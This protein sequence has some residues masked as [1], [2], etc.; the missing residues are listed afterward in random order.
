MD[1][2]KTTLRVQQTVA[3][4]A[5]S[6]HRQLVPLNSTIQAPTGQ[7]IP[8][9][10]TGETQLAPH[11][12]RQRSMLDRP[13]PQEMTRGLE[14][15]WISAR[16]REL[17]S[18]ENPNPQRFKTAF[19]DTPPSSPFE[20]W[21]PDGDAAE[22]V[23]IAQTDDT[24]EHHTATTTTT[25]T[26]TTALQDPDDFLDSILHAD[27][28]I[29]VEPDPVFRT[30][31]DQASTIEHP[32]PIQNPGTPAKPGNAFVEAIRKGMSS[33]QQAFAGAESWT[34][35]RR[36][37]ASALDWIVHCSDQASKTRDAI[38]VIADLVHVLSAHPSPVFLAHIKAAALGLTERPL[39]RTWLVAG[40]VHLAQDQWQAARHW[41]FKSAPL[42]G[43]GG[44]PSKKEIAVLLILLD[45]ERGYSTPKVTD[46]AWGLVE[47]QLTDAYRRLSSTQRVE[48]CEALL[49]AIASPRDI[50]P[51]FFGIFA[52]HKWESAS[53]WQQAVSDEY[54]LRLD[55]PPD[56][57]PP[58]DTGPGDDERKEAA[59]LA[60]HLAR[61]R[62]NLSD[63]DGHARALGW[64]SLKFIRILAIH[65]K[66]K[67]LAQTQIVVDDSNFRAPA[68]LK[69]IATTLGCKLDQALRNFIRATLA[70]V[71]GD[72][73]EKQ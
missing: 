27:D 18:P 70:P 57:S 4:A 61:S 53:P 34:Q 41:A 56:I 48:M 20:W 37:A 7:F 49:S 35:A 21:A 26:T 23:D 33:A 59:A 32:A 3:G 64:R 11:R 25:T 29:V 68:V 31:P 51:D 67:V 10:D 36:V 17:E 9:L 28:E 54:A 58:C 69:A 16:K 5:D 50:S 65:L 46:Q 47:T 8:Y 45:A 60:S 6:T 39:L 19:D 52:L 73:K 30:E 22:H 62:F 72:L 43:D 44:V 2:G 14:G 55:Q 1:V 12:E 40:A 71:F 24:E 42:G 13:A 15:N 66:A 63:I 38:H